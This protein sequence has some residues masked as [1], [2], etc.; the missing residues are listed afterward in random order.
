MVFLSF[1]HLYLINICN[2]S[3]YWYCKGMYISKFFKTDLTNFKVNVE[4]SIPTRTLK[5]SQ[6]NNLPRQGEVD[7][8]RHTRDEITFCWSFN[9]PSCETHCNTILSGRQ[10]MGWSWLLCAGLPSLVS[11]CL[12]PC[13]WGVGSSASRE[14]KMSLPKGVEVGKLVQAPAL[15]R[16]QPGMMGG[17]APT[18]LVGNRLSPFSCSDCSQ[19]GFGCNWSSLPPFC[20][21]R[22]WPALSQ[23]GWAGL[24]TA[25]ASH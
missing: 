25:G 15:L 3:T 14:G 17:Q 5:D 18:T 21:S 9:K 6:V 13:Y 23:A 2:C 8:L 12:L 1:L 20:S 24:S 11:E 4:Q 22:G 16:A 19:R 10:Q 7:L